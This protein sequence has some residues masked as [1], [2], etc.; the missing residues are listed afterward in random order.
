MHMNLRHSILFTSVPWFFGTLTDLLVGGWLV[1]AL[2]QRGDD[3]LCRRKTVSDRR[4][5]S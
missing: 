3:Q 5:G 2:V 1:D 4:N